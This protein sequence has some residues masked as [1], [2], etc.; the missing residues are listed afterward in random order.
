MIGADLDE[1]FLPELASGW[2]CHWPF[3]SFPAGGISVALHE[4]FGWSTL[5]RFS[6]VPFCRAP[7]TTAVQSRQ[8]GRLQAAKAALP[9]HQRS[10]W[11][12]LSVQ[13]ALN[14]Y[15]IWLMEKSLRSYN[16]SKTPKMLTLLKSIV[17][18]LQA[19]CRIIQVKARLQHV[20][21]GVPPSEKS[22]YQRI[23]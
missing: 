13:K 20:I 21:I 2:G 1:F 16:L 14:M 23:I 7:Y 6:A 17:D 3:W 10:I 19:R 11:C 18:T 12:A 15:H 8:M 4:I 22:I 5:F 9:R